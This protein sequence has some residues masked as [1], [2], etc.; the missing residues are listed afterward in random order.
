M[1]NNEAFANKARKYSRRVG[2]VAAT[3]TLAACG[4]TKPNKP[5]AETAA[6]GS[7]PVA[8]GGSNP[9]QTSAPEATATPNAGDGMSDEQALQ[10]LTQLGSGNVF[11]H[12]G[13]QTVED[14]IVE[15]PIVQAEEQ[16]IGVDD[17]QVRKALETEAV[18]SPA[19]DSTVKTP[20]QLSAHDVAPQGMDI[21]F[22][23][24]QAE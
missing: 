7:V 18:I 22:T 5:S 15:S 17:G 11:V 1:S 10:L 24:R 2:V 4:A 20:S 6:N 9:N 14:V 23:F 3:L 19:P 13:G 8:V 21:Q 16:K 12:E